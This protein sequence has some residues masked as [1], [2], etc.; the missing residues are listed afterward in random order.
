[1]RDRGERLSS[2]WSRRSE[3]PR[4]AGPFLFPVG[5]LWACMACSEPNPELL[6]DEVLQAELGLTLDDR[7]HTVTL[8]GGGAERVEPG[9]AT[10]AEGD[11]VQFLSTDWFVHEVTFESDSLGDAAL[12]FMERTDQ[13]DSPPLIYKD[14]R[15]VVSFEDAPPGRYPFVVAGNGRPGRGVIVL[16]ESEAR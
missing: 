16:A 5:I 2:S 14:S 15:F 10:V 7:V 1:M 3:R 6:P 11:F 4:L 9:V 13:L 12:A 8:T